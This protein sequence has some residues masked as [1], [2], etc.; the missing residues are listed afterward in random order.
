MRG[1]LWVRR[2]EAADDR[3]QAERARLHGLRAGHGEERTV[4][5]RLMM[6]TLEV[7]KLSGWLNT[8]ACCRESNGGHMR[9]GA[10]YTGVGRRE[11]ADDRG[12]C[13]QRA[14]EGSIA[15]WGHAGHGE[16]RT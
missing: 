2:R 6:V 3:M 8:Y 13:K 5:M 11:A 10:R 9:C 12:G 16:E 4:N 14:G 15:D 7:S 1:E